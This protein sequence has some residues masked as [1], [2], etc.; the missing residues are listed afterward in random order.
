LV[1]T[2]VRERITKTQIA[3]RIDKK[4][5]EVEKLSN[6]PK[7]QN[8]EEYQQMVKVK[9]RTGNKGEEEEELDLEEQ[10]KK[11]E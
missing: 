3:P 1:K 7:N 2:K 10:W 4:K 5:W 8:R 11:I 6:D 9:L